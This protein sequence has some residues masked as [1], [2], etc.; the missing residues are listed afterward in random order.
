[1]EYMPT[2]LIPKPSEND[3][4]KKIIFSLSRLLR[5]T[6]A[7]ADALLALEDIVGKD[8]GNAS[9]SASRSTSGGFLTQA[10]VLSGH[11]G[12]IYTCSFSPMGEGSGE[13]DAPL[14]AT[15]GFDRTVR[16]WN[17]DPPYGQ[18]ACLSREHTLPVS[19]IAWGWGEEGRRHLVSCGLDGCIVG[20]DTEAGMA[21][22]SAV[23]MKSEFPP[24]LS[25]YE[26]LGNCSV[27]TAH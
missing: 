1:M 15:G 18:L 16:L 12:A 6:R 23:R 4:L 21:A 9:E 26:L 19:C 20:W 25:L 2:M 24:L 22:L 7:D 8:E 5:R 17:A 13:Q 10:A 27:L 3:K 14:L 11:M